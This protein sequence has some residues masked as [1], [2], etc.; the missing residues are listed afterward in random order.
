MDQSTP[1]PKKSFKKKHKWWLTIAVAFIGVCVTFIGI[2][3]T[4]SE[5]FVPSKFGTCNY[6]KNELI[7]KEA[8]LKN[9]QIRISLLHGAEDQK[10]SADSLAHAIEI[11]NIHQ[12]L[13]QHSC[14]E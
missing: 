8:E 13:N 11:L 10:L 9:L 4:N 12:M 5:K 2:F 1:K 14:N 3:V 7:K 6:L